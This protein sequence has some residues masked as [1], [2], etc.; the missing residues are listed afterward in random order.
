MRLLLIAALSLCALF[1]D[2]YIYTNIAKRIPPD[3]RRYMRFFYIGYALTIDIFLFAFIFV[4][5]RWPFY[6]PR[7]V[8][9]LPLWLAWFFFLNTIPKCAYFLFYVVSKCVGVNLGKWVRMIGVGFALYAAFLLLKGALYNT[10]FFEVKE[11]S[12]KS[13][14]IPSSFDGYRMAL[15]SDVHLGNLSRKGAFL[16][17]F[18]KQ[19]QQL[20]PDII[21]F[22]GDLVNMYASEI[23]PD[24]QAIFSQLTAPDGIYT[25]LGNHDMGAYFGKRA[26]KFGMTPSGNTH[27]IIVRQRNMGWMVLQNESIQIVRQGDSIGLCGVPYPPIPPLFQKLLSDFDPMLA[28][29]LLNPAQFNIMLCHTPKVWVEWSN[30]PPLAHID[31]MLSGHT[32]AMQTKVQ[33]GSRRWSPAQWMYHFW[34]GLY[35]QNGR[36]LYVNEGLGYVLYP[37]RMGSKPEITLFT[38]V[39]DT[40]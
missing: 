35:E 10:R 5:Y 9:P 38:L 12:I 23:T 17:K 28:T 3:K 18:V 20:N 25:V 37:M 11:V 1:V 7:S 6:G 2:C 29:S 27:E 32:H 14:K 34:S 26:A 15:F 21:L 31:L 33:F 8:S 16:T 22:A 36:Y 4:C 30:T 24:I 39:N 19:V 40:P 13:I